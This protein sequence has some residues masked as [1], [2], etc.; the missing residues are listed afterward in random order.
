MR[1]DAMDHDVDWQAIFFDPQIDLPGKLSSYA[2]RRFGSS[3]DAEAAYNDALEHV[4]ADDWRR[5]RDSYKGRGSPAGF[6]RIAFVR[7]IEDYA[8]GKYGKRRPPVWVQRLG[9][10]WKR[11]YELL[12]LRRLPPE[13]IVG[14]LTARG[15]VE[16]E[17]VRFA[18]AQIRGRV[19]GCGQYTGEY[20]AEDPTAGAEGHGG[21][22]GDL[23][24]DELTTLLKVMSSL[25]A[26]ERE[27]VGPK[28]AAS[29]SV[30]QM[31]AGIIA[32]RDAL[33][34]ALAISDEERLIL[35]LVY[36]DGYSIAKAA[37]ALRIHEQ[38]VRRG[39]RAAI[40]RLREALQRFGIDSTAV[41][42]LGEAR[43]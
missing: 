10:V 21:S 30:E 12:C 1:G 9:Q 13:T 40:D 3:P 2:R 35:K 37:R 33:R 24:K 7:L 28:T 39:H 20:A 6:I 4:S 22:T 29:E 36:Q 14:Y 34:A 17:R 38:K 32:N 23:E 25:I 16:P 5:L 27:A 19:T 31:T 15:T 18:I 42:R 26:G 41:S 11:V 8:I 43:R